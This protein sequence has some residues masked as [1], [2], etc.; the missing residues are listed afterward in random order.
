MA[1]LRTAYEEALSLIASGD[2]PT[3]SQTPAYMVAADTLN[4]ANGNETFLEAAV[5][6]IDNIPKFIATSVIS[7]ANQLYNIPADVGNLV[8]GEGTFERSDTGEVISA[9]DSDLGQFYKEHQEGSDLVGFFV[10]SLVPGIAGIKVL[11]AGQKSLRTAI[12]AGKF[13]ENTGKALGLLAPQKQTF[14]SRAIKEVSTNSSAATLLNRNA[15]KA[16]ASGFGQNA[17]E[18]LAFET[19]IAAT[20]FKSPILEN[21]D[22]GDFVSNVAFGAGVFGLVGGAVDAAKISFSLKKA[23]DKA[24]VEARPWTFI[25]EPAKAST[26]YER[27]V[28]DYEQLGRIPPI[29][30][31]ISPERAAFLTSA[32]ATKATRLENR[33][34]KN[35]GEI[36]GGDQ[37]VAETMFQTFK[38][39]TVH[40]QQAAFIGIVEATKFGAKAKIADK[41][42]RIQSKVLQGTAS[43]KEIKEF[44]DSSIMVSYAKAWGEAA[45]KL[46][47]EKPR[48]T[49]LV[50]TLKK[51]EQIKVT[52]GGVKAGSKKFQFS[53]VFNKSQKP[54]KAVAWNILKA[55]PL[56]ANARYIWASKLP[57]FEPTAKSPLKIDVNDIP[58]MEKVMADVGGKP[59]ELIHVKFVGLDKDEFIGNSLQ[60]FLGDKKLKLAHRLLAIKGEPATVLKKG[61][62]PLVQEEIAAIINVKS[63]FLSGEVL[64][65]P[66]NSYALKDMLAMQDHAEEFTAKLIA[67]GSRRPKDGIVD[68]WAIPQHVK[69]TYDSKQFEGINN[70]VV[71]NMAIIKE[72]QRLYQEGTSRA[73]AVIL[74]DDY[75]KLE[76]INSGKVFAGAVPSGAGAGFA[77]AASSNYGTLAAT[78]ENIGNV[79]SRLIEKFKNR[80][81]ETLEP[82]LYKLGNNQEA[83]VEWSALNQRVRAIEGEY[84]LNA[85]GNALEPIAILRWK[86]ATVDAAEQGK[87]APKQPTLTNPA[88]ELEIPIKHQETRDLMR[89]HIEVNGMRTNGLAGIRTAQ[90]LQFN[91]APDA[92]YPI[93]I[94]PKDFP[95]FALVIDESI[96][97]GNHSKTLFASSAEELDGMIKK[98]K[99]NPQLKILTKNEAEAYHSSRGT[100]DYEK[101]LNNNYLDVEAHRKG[102]SAPFLV[103]T[104]P[105][106]ITSDMLGWHMQ[107]ETGLVREAV[108]TKYEVQ[109]EELRRLGEEFTDVATSRFSDSNLLKFADDAV[110]NPF[111]DYI[112]TA[113]GIRKTSDYPWW[114]Q[115]NQMAD[116]AVSKLLKR[117]TAVVETTKSPEELASVNRMLEKGGYKGAAY[118]ESMVIFANA[119]P[120]KGA[121]SSVVQKANSILATIVLRWDALNAVNN[122]VSSTVL[123]GAEAQAVVRA[124]NRGDAEAVGALAK[125]AKVKV[126]GTDELIMAPQKLIANA[127]KKFN[128]N[129]EEMK[130]YKD[131]GYV[132]TISSQYRDALDSI[133]FTGKESIASWDSRV[134]KLHTSLRDLANKGERWTGNRLAEEFNRFVAAD[135]MKQLTDVAVTRGLMQPKEA[136]AYIN[137]FVNRTQGNYLA[138]QR[139][140]MFQGPIGQAIGLFQT[141]QFNLIQQL[142]RHAGEGHAK[143]S[144]TLL[145][146]QG[147]IHGMN[148]LPGFNA[149]NT[150]LVGTASGNKEHRDAYDTVYG[151]AGKEAGDWIMYGAASN[152]L[153]LLHPDLKINLYTRGDINPRH[154]TIVP[155]NPSSVPIVQASGKFFKNLFTTA[156][157]LAAG[158]DVTTTL[159]Q[160]LEHNGLSRPLAGLAQTLQ[161][162]ENPQAASYST[163]KKGNVIAANDFLS[164]ANLARMVGGKP[165]DEAVAIDA[166]Y[167]FKAYALADA[168]KRMVIGQAIKTTLIAGKET[169]QDQIDDFAEQYASAGGKSEQFNQWFTQLYKTANMSQANKIKDQL[170]RSWEVRSLGTLLQRE[171][172]Q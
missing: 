148:G 144:M 40:D 35:M 106:K 60:E 67:Q 47:T 25:D 27:L 159:L 69:L 85:A 18:A 154:V 94:N 105:Q 78:T 107:R 63:S 70:F 89:A 102:V 55:D 99:E 73:S 62:E 36:A 71:E 151:I 21:Q 138:A 108:A 119:E 1:E 16:V 52:L 33:I 54:T 76:D 91:R 30:A 135:V 79:T 155:T 6:T 15:L 4:T 7:G 42:E 132:T 125:L 112:K 8:S 32:A 38:A 56:E 65:D 58:L 41:A 104:D 114:V 92:F 19:A 59:E 98:L 26:T 97:S 124:I 160:G 162:L 161:G 123:L 122:A 39:A 156:G 66:V 80:T 81:R 137:T 86:Q 141:Y 51:G 127:I 128:R 147:T 22:F 169:S 164:V 11:N 17:L 171:G 87:A 117:A 46:M 43:V 100:W 158:G 9:L 118:D 109:F 163:S 5:D 29:P 77:T 116:A 13:G 31:G 172:G 146:L 64:R 49:S 165:L 88:M 61:K 96:T 140:M 120:A 150:H 152:A 93:P 23:A 153:G 149:L 126:P 115:P 133:T 143:D 3:G 129:S 37:D 142:L 130:F 24:A 20:L 2:D 50:D 157:K 170:G 166:T 131:N 53:T 139:P 57:K 44:A 110:K 95:H 68:I 167:R 103:A 101:T 74:G 75:A 90:G 121:L 168:K 34:R 48:I 83:A 111:A 45:G 14:I 84:G 145:A 113:L 72:Q 12:G 10:S 28:L 134:N 82:L 136:L